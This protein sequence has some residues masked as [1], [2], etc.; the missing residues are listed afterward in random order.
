MDFLR[1]P[2]SIDIAVTGRCNL[3]CAYCSHFTS[4]G[5]VEDLPADEWCR[6]FEELERRGVG[7]V[8]FQGGEPFFRD[9][10]PGLVRC[11][12]ARG[13]R[14]SILSNGT[15]ISDELA[16]FISSTGSCDSVQVSIDGSIPTTHESFR[17]R[18][19]FR[20]ALDGL[21][22]LLTHGVPASVRVTIHKRNV[23]DL[24]NIAA[25]L[26]EEIGLPGFSTNSASHFGL[27]R[28]NADQVQLTVEERSLAMR[29][30]IKLKERYGDRISAS[31]GPLAEAMTWSE[32]ESAM[33][34]GE[35]TLACGG[36]L[37][38]CGG[39]MQSLAVRADGVIV[40]CLQLPHMELGRI[41][42]DDLIDVW[43]NS[44]ELNRLR[45][46]VEIPL[47]SFAF[48]RDCDYVDYCTGNCP[49]AAHTIERDAWRPSPDACYRLFKQSGGE[50]PDLP[51]TLIIAKAKGDQLEYSLD[52]IYF[53]LTRGC[54][55][56][57]RH[58]W[59]EPQFQTG[60]RTY[61]SLDFDLFVS[62]L[63]QAQALGLSG[64][65]LTGGEP[66][67][68][69]RIDNIL[70]EIQR[71]ELGL[72]IETNG[73]ACTAD[74]AR[75]IRACKDAS[76][77][78]SL[79]GA[80][81]ETHEWM[82]G[83]AGSF[84]A[85]ITGVRNLV[86]AGFKPQ[87]IMTVCRQNKH[88]IESLVRLAEALG[89][90]SVKFNLVQPT[91][92]G[93]KMHDGGEALSVEELVSLGRWVEVELSLS[94]TLE[95][96]FDHPAA[97]RPLSRLFG[98]AGSGCYRCGIFG[99]LGVLGDGSYALCGIGETVPEL[100]F[101]HAA[102][103][104]LEDVWRNSPVLNELRKGLPAKLEGVCGRC[105]MK[106]LCLGACVASNY[107]RGGRLWSAY[108]YCEEALASGLFPKTRLS[109]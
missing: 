94:T 43:R 62:V 95:L 41:N 81:A 56:H 84:E 29:T 33:R 48:C 87:I 92:R 10:F 67:I 40:P 11:A 54:N 69:P 16:A 61:P 35:R 12:S 28:K 90:G 85:A 80:D 50:L 47:R 59:I 8:C 53:Y 57:C 98:P 76:V 63:D 7:H 20:R 32:M 73:V 109:T 89:A 6:F 91:A 68:H 36:Y 3:K 86:D 13:I 96:F 24:E 19:T 105:L 22:T 4:E 26:L 5:D 39:P 79:D 97:F 51:P 21:M 103:D 45:R 65:K 106:H 23:E 77:S 17:G 2:E 38:G 78:V 58:C 49:A 44:S 55:L 83:V 60:A 42:K 64:V 99:I 72:T 101:G 14:F 93:Q 18:G 71:R 31:A 108:W 75:R 102:H 34:R 100:V 82:R 30:L 66:L 37:T 9:D 74:L 52:Q 70:D 107:Q 46:R 27:C 1:S 15:L 25:L 88:D 104:R